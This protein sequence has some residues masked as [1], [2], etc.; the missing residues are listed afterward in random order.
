MG[1]ARI[2][3]VVVVCAAVVASACA[4]KADKITASYVS[5]LIYENYDCNQLAAEGQRLGAKAAQVAGVQDK[6]ATNDAVAMGVGLV[7]FWPSLF[8]IKGGKQ[9]EAELAQLR[10]QMNALVPRHRGFDC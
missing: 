7:L 9:T 5:P 10:G 2:F 8:F 1:S 6:Q 4:K 3:A